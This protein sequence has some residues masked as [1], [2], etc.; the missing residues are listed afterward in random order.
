MPRAHRSNLL[1]VPLAVSLFATFAG[2][3]VS[4]APLPFGTSLL[5][6]EPIE[7]LP[8]APPP[9]PPA[10]PADVAA[11]PPGAKTTASGLASKVLFKGKGSGHPG[12]RDRVTVQYTGWTPDGTVF[13]SSV[14]RGEPATFRLDGVIKGWTEGLQLMVK[15]EK[16]RFWIPAD[17]AYGET[18]TRPGTPAGALVFDVELLD[19]VYVPAPPQVPE[20]VASPP[21]EAQKTASGLAYRFLKHGSGKAHPTPDSTVQVH[22]SGWTPDGKLFD[23]SVT[24]GQP[25]TF[26]LDGVIK[27]WTEGLQLMV[28]GDKA[29]FW[30][31][32]NLAYGDKPSRPGTPAGTLVFDVELLSIQ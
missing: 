11:A 23:S 24:R 31:P 28:V 6:A 30:I 4:A 19:F 16:R 29:R 3:V 15:G 32:G 22:Y 26:P 21:K 12:P 17:L 9:S 25:T 14:P 5:A 18:P 10:A 7:P 27:G 1:F 2:G 13:D 20:D 8:S